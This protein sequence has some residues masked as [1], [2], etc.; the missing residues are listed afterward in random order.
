[1]PIFKL[2]ISRTEY[3]RGYIEIEAKDEDDIFNKYYG[4]TTE[5]IDY[6]ELNLID[7]SDEILS[8]KKIGED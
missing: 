5:N 6:D 3:K 2:L 8:I 7:A 4:E 1:M